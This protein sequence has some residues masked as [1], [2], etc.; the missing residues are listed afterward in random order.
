MSKGP[1]KI[2]VLY[3]PEEKVWELVSRHDITCINF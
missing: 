2:D 1:L 3:I